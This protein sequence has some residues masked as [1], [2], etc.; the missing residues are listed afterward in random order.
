[1]AGAP[2]PLPDVP[3]LLVRP[4]DAPPFVA[5]A[6]LHLGL[7]ASAERPLGPPEASAPDLA[8]DLVAILRRAHADR[9]VIAGD[10]KHPILGTPRFLRPVVFDFFATLLSEGLAVDIVLG[11][12]DVGLVPHLPREVTAHP[13]SGLRVGDVGV[14]H[15]HRWP[16]AAVLRAPRLV[17]GH[18]HP[19]YRLASTAESPLGKR[20]CWV[21]VELPPPTRRVRRRRRHEIRAREVIV[22]PAFHPFA[23]TESLNRDRP[24]RTRSFLYRRFVA[25]GTARAYLLDGTDLGILPTPPGPS[26]PRRGRG[27]R[28][29]R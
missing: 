2:T 24:Q 9:L 11:N 22:V 3:A 5:I 18:L 17:V 28:P 7:E 12:H 21:R 19:G 14:F 10:A 27:A 15:G 8:H 20:R 23:G 13:S 6:D 1:V 16:S 4:E 29:A 25:A 26:P